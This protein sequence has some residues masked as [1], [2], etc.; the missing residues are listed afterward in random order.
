M[1]WIKYA[2]VAIIV[3]GGTVYF[4]LPPALRAMGLHQHYEIPKFD[5]TG[6][7]ALVVTTSHGT[8]GDTGRATGVA[9]SELTVPYYAFLDAGMTVD[10]ASIKRRRNSCGADD[11]AMADCDR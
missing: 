8:L 7:R 4:G 9:A 3:L 5:L 10:L 1:S 11:E 2:L 6:K